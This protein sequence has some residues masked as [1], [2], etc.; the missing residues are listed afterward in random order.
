MIFPVMR[1]HVRF[2]ENSRF[3]P[4]K[5]HEWMA[6]LLGV[7]SCCCNIVICSFS[8]LKECCLYIEN[9]RRNINC[10]EI[11]SEVERVCNQ[12]IRLLSLH[13]SFK[14]FLFFLPASET[15]LNHTDIINEDQTSVS[16][17]HKV[18]S[19]KKHTLQHI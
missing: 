11:A 6:K 18:V 7:V 4:R 5:G 12:N 19:P 2:L 16:M 1:L 3:T 13:V 10:V 8:I 14:L 9:L 17:P 15:I